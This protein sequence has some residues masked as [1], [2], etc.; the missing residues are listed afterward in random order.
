MLRF[1]TLIMGLCCGLP[2]AA[3]SCGGPESPCEVGRGTYHAALPIEPAGAPFV[4]FLHGY[5]GSGA[6]AVRNAGSAA[7]YTDRGYALLAPTGQRDPEERFRSDWGVDDGFEMPR[8]DVAF[9]RAVI[10]DAAERFGLN[11]E[12]VLL[13]GFSRGGSMVW[14]AA[15]ADPTL[16]KAYAAAAGGFWEPIQTTCAAPVHLF[17]THGFNDRQVPLEGRTVTFNGITFTQG[18]ILKGLDTWRQVNGCTGSAQSRTETDW[19]KDWPDCASGSLTLRLTTGGHGLPKG[20]AMD[21]LDWFET[22][23]GDQ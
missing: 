20:W 11:R 1:A 3:Q 23:T 8:D 17:H 4:V 9:L 16:A 5:G 21:M 14:D 12:R 15:C 10:D 19:I 7:R 13:M 2:L 22:K 6:S 18:N